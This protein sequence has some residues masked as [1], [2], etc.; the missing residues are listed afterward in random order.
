MIHDENIY[1]S[2]Q[3][4]DGLEGSEKEAWLYIK[5]LFF[6]DGQTIPFPP[7]AAGNIAHGLISLADE[8]TKTAIIND[9]RL[10]DD[11]HA[12]GAVVHRLAVAVESLADV[13]GHELGSGPRGARQSAASDNQPSWDWPTP[14]YC[15]NC[16]VLWPAGGS[17][18]CSHQ[19][20]DE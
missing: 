17:H 12:I 13:L 8:I 11:H 3:V 4:L 15:G 7:S 5:G 14:N 6:S 2:M 10:G 20:N 18:E 9:G 16:H 1:I 19:N